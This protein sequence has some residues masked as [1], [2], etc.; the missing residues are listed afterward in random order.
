MNKKLYIAGCSYT[1]RTGVR[2][3]YGDFLYKM[4]GVE[5]VHLAA[6]GSSND[7]LWRKLSTLILDGTI[8]TDDLVIVQYTGIQRREFYSSDKGYAGEQEKL[9]Q[10]R[11]LDNCRSLEGE[12]GDVPC[13]EKTNCILFPEQTYHTSQFK[14]GSYTWQGNEENKKLHHSYE[15]CSSIYDYDYDYFL[16]RHKQFSALCQ[17][18]KI[19]IIFF[20]TRYIQGDVDIEKTYNEYDMKNLLIESDFYDYDNTDF[21]LGYACSAPGHWDSQHMNE[22]GHEFVAKNIYSHILKLGLN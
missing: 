21:D 8:S 1:D 14:F 11:S 6:G 10:K 18:H 19:N 9:D 3:N 15:H 17:L 22:L 2:F 12:K 13:I 4:L 5:Y 20:H 16:C 7:R